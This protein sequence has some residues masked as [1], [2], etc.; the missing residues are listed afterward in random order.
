MLN[1]MLLQ[2]YDI[3]IDTSIGLN[4]V[5]FVPDTD[6][7][8]Q[9]FYS[10]HVISIE[11]IVILNTYKIGHTVMS[12]LRKELKLKPK[13]AQ[14]VIEVIDHEDT[15]T[16]EFHFIHRL[17]TDDGIRTVSDSSYTTK[18]H[19]TTAN[20]ELENCIDMFNKLIDRRPIEPKI[21]VIRLPFDGELCQKVLTYP[22][23]W[24]QSVQ[25][26]DVTVRIPLYRSIFQSTSFKDAT[27]Y[28]V[29][30]TVPG[31][32]LMT[33]ELITTTNNITIQELQFGYVQNF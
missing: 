29:E 11:P 2:C 33:L 27:V 1:R 15:D 6:D 26:G 30:T 7:F 8:T 9:E 25:V 13:A 12:D 24:F 32:Y 22:D 31:I 19:I 16:V 5:I 14:E 10:D 21:G 23:I 3:N 28:V 20:L 18:L 17:E 4:S